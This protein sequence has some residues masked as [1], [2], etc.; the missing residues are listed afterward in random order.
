M[1]QRGFTLL[2]VLVAVV[3]LGMLIGL[4]GQGLAF[5][6]RVVAVQ[7]RASASDGLPLADAT[8][9]R[10]IARADPGIYPEPAS[11]KGTSTTLTMVTEVTGPDGGPR[12]IDAVLFVAEG[13]LRLRSSVHRHVEAF[14]P[15]RADDDVLLLGVTGMT[16]DY[17]DARSGAWRPA[18][19]ADTLPALVRIRLVMADR[20]HPWPPIVVAPE[21]EAPGQ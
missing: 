3:V 20:V 13:A 1:R 15:Q 6:T 12:P 19:L 4:L 5:A 11:L 9:R 21:L 2:E 17:A 18:W 16:I 14:G 10:L 8:L 7:A